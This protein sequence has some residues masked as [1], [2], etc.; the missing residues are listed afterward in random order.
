[1][2]KK[3]IFID[4]D[5]TLIKCRVVNGIPLPINNIDQFKF[6]YG[7][8]KYLKKLSLQYEIILI[9]NQPD[10]KIKGFFIIQNAINKEIKKKLPNITLEYFYGPKSDKFF[11]KPGPGMI[12]K[13]VNL[14][15][16]DLSKSFMIGDRWR[17]IG[18]AHNSGIKNSCLIFNNNYIENS[19]VFKP[20][21][22]FKSLIQALRFIDD[23][24]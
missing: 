11:Y 4:R 2:K 13:Y 16:L 19:Y 6:N 8:L 17:D 20:R 1:M 21:Y 14:L 23:I 12:L 5:G 7:A 15:D 22:E 24:K 10:Y 3:A 9:S 18:A